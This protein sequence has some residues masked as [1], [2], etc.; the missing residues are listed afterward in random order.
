MDSSRNPFGAPALSVTSSSD[1]NVSEITNDKSV[2]DSS[3]CSPQND[4]KSQPTTANT[5]QHRQQDYATAVKTNVC[6]NDL[7]MTDMSADDFQEVKSRRKR[8]RKRSNNDTVIGRKPIN[9]L[10]TCAR[11][12]RCHVFVSRLGPDVSVLAVKEFCQSM[13]DEDC[14]VLKLKTKYATYTSFKI[15]CNIWKKEVILN[16]DSWEAG[17]FVRPFYV[18]L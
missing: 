13:L 11:T 18:S 1:E 7:N 10:G 17:V 9:H 15:T 2:F 4:P 5:K 16:P 8:S 3:L 6:N 14:E 12:S